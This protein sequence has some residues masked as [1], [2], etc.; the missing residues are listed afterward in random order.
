MLS[1][2]NLLMYVK[3]RLALPSTFIEKSDTEIMDWIK[4]TSL[5][6]FSNYYPD[7]EFTAV[8]ADNPSYKKTGKTGQF[9]FFDEE[10]LEILGIK[11][12]YFS[13]EKE[14]LTGHPVFGPWDFQDHKWWALNVFKSRFF[15]T[16]TQLHY[17]Y[18]FYPPNIVHITPHDIDGNFAIEYE[19]MQ[20]PD[21]RK[22][23]PSL[24]TNFMDLSLAEVMIWIGSIRSH[25]G[26][27]TIQVPF[28][29]GIPLKGEELLQR[30]EELKRNVVEKLAEG[31]IPSIIIDIE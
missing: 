9:Y 1:W 6:E 4:L 16:F 19:R 29:G 17:N 31:T 25:Y 11:Q 21:L 18:K 23:P 10:D 2:S 8:L 27:D 3:G 7:V 26:G 14:L 22:I 20:P 30:G 15:S 28:G 13:L 12:C 5:R 24:I